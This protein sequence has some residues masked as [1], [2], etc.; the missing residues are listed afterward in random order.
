MPRRAQA[1]ELVDRSA[2]LDRRRVGH[3]V[4]AEAPRFAAQLRPS[5]SCVSQRA[6]RRERSCHAAACSCR[7]ACGELHQIADLGRRVGRQPHRHDEVDLRQLLTERGRCLDVGARGLLAR[8]CLGIAARTRSRTRSRNGS[9]RRS[10]RWNPRG[11]RRSRLLPRRPALASRSVDNEAARRA[12][13]RP[14]D[15]LR[16]ERRARVP[17]TRAPASASSARAAACFTSTPVS[18]SRRQRR[19]D[20]RASRRHHP[21]R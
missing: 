16:R 15:E 8:A 5:P 6:R 1:I 18:R 3:R 12:V 7:R 19:V 17:L 9:R 14:V 4:A 20:A 13:E 11:S 21:T 2:E 10:A